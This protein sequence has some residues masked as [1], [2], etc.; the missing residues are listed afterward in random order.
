MKIIFISNNLASTHDKNRIEEFVSNGADVIVYGFT[1]IADDGRIRE[2]SFYRPLVVG[3]LARSYF[4][5]ILTY[6]KAIREI[7][8]KHKSEKCIYYLFGFDMGLIFLLQN[9]NEQ[10]IYE[11]ADLV[12][13]Y[14]QN[15]FCVKLLKKID[16]LIIKRS[17]R[18]VLTSEGFIDY[19]KSIAYLKKYCIIPNKLSLDIINCDYLKKDIPNLSKLKIGFVGAPRFNS[20]HNFIKVYCQNFPQ[21]EFHIYGGPV[22]DQ[23]N[24]LKKFSNCIFHGRFTSPID[25]PEIYSNIDMVLC[26]YDVTSDNVK[27]AEPNKIYESIYF[28]TPIIVSN[29][30]FLSSKVERLGV[31]FSIDA[32]NDSEIIEFIQTLTIDKI[33]SCINCAKMIPKIECLNNNKAFIEDVMGK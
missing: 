6:W 8:R 24:D 19:H 26:T 13:T 21:Y 16:E 22:P 20:I 14:I 28:E 25:L 4:G 29:K 18:T 10:Y 5:R 32:M 11:E 30:T 9:N 17:Y 27:Y 2:S 7:R 31:G 23:F 12:Y 3:N 15:S 1:R 33:I